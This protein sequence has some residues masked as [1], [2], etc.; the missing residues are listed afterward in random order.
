MGAGAIDAGLTTYAAT[1]FSPRSVNWLH[2]CYGVGATIGPL[3]MT[4]VLMADRPWQWGYGIVG[5]W[6]LLLAACFGLTHRRWPIPR[7]SAETSASASVRAASSSSTLRLPVVWL[8]MAV[9]SIYTGLEAAAGVWTYSLFTEARAIPSSTAGMWVSVYWGGLTAGRLLSGIAVGFVPVRLLLRLCIIGIGLGATLVWLHF[10]DL[11]SFLGLA[12]M[13][14]SAAP[15]FPTLIATTP[16]RLGDA[17]TAN[18]VGFQIAAAV[19]GQ[20]LLPAVLGVLARTQGLEIVGPSLLTAAILLLALYEVLMT[21]SGKHMRLVDST[22]M[23][24]GLRPPL[25]AQAPR[26]R[27]RA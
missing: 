13:G 8:S 20:S 12:L 4:S 11:L 14:L 22:V 21:T 19:L 16:A 3:I 26:D 27:G 23:A 6:Q 10:A 15:V 17:H 7:T 9:F 24:P 5:V 1:H 25:M 2:A 18:G